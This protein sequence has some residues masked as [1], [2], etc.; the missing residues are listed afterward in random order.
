MPQK[1]LII[2]D[3]DTG[4]LWTINHGYNAFYLLNMLQKQIAISQCTGIESL[5]PSTSL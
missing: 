2:W 5:S 3:K 1:K 4:I